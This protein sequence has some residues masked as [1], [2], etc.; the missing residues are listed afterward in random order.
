MVD[1]IVTFA[2]ERESLAAGDFSVARAAASPA[3]GSI[4]ASRVSVNCHPPQ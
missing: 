2:F 3:G 1:F 4:G